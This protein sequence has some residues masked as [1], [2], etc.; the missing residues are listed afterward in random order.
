MSIIPKKTKFHLSFR[1]KL[2][3]YDKKLNTFKCLSKLCKTSIAWHNDSK[4]TTFQ[5]IKFFKQ[6]KNEQIIFNEFAKKNAYVAHWPCSFKTYFKTKYLTF[7][8]PRLQFTNH[9][10]Q[11]IKQSFNCSPVPAMLLTNYESSSSYNESDTTS[12]LTLEQHGRN[13]YKSRTEKFNIEQA[14]SHFLKDQTVQLLKQQ[15]Q[16]NFSKY[17]HAYNSCLLFGQ[18]GICFEQNGTLSAQF[19]ETVRL[20]CARKLKKKGRCWLRICCQT[21]V[22]ARPAETRMGKG[23]G[24]ISFWQAKVVTGQLFFEFSGL[25]QSTIIEIFKSLI[26]KSPLKLKLIGA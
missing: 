13:F 15:T 7:N 24:A 17:A 1:N 21:P 6:P 2:K 14:G 9:E 26:K 22:T 18:Y 11:F 8:Q 20:I 16:Q 19:I 3:N 4:K 25:S 12:S 10:S 23:K 5:K